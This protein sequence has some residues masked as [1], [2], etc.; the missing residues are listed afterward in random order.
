MY[1]FVKTQYSAYINGGQS[2]GIEKI[3]KIADLYLT[4]EQRDEI[5]GGG[6]NE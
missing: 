4:A 6:K 2:V 5:F 1:E 3:R